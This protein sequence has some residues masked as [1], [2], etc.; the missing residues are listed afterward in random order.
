[1]NTY[2][3]PQGVSFGK[4]TTFVFCRCE[5]GFPTMDTRTYLLYCE[6]AQVLVK[7]RCLIIQLKVHHKSKN[8]QSFDEQA[9]SGILI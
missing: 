5:L 6:I 4:F 8:R 3:K 9:T 1:M 2:S 7:H